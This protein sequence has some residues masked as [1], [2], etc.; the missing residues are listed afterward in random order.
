MWRDKEAQEAIAF[1]AEQA[2]EEMRDIP[3]SD[4][5]CDV[6][7]IYFWKE[8]EG[9]YKLLE[10]DPAEFANAI[11]EDRDLFTVIPPP[12]NGRAQCHVLRTYRKNYA[13]KHHVKFEEYACMYKGECKG[14]CQYCEQEAESL[15]RKAE[16]LPLRIEKLSLLTTQIAG[17]M[18]LRED[19]DG[20]GIRSLV[21]FDG[22][23]LH[24]EYCINRDTIRLLPTKMTLD[25]G[26]LGHLLMEDAVY[27]EM[28]GGG[29]TF[30]GGEPLQYYGF[31][32]QF[33][34]MY[35]MWDIAIETSLN[36]PLKNVKSLASK[37]N[38]W[39]IDIKDM[40]SDIYYCY[41]GL[42]NGQVI[43]NLQYLIDSGFRDR[44]TCRV[45]LIPGYNTKED[46]EQSVSY[47][48]WMG[49]I[50][51]DYFTYTVC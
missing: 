49:I 14:T 41:T 6:Y 39:Y 48:K 44:I 1:F 50:H 27:F 30:G 45:P 36:M 5:H 37:I 12:K 40:D 2:K 7:H 51:F 35:P 32:A 13:K 17:I 33:H 31:I 26:T 20:P 9:K 19:M 34:E 22:C 43:I 21:V 15:F 28:T 16:K 8:Q 29:V 47:L 3:F 11:L 46:V 24:C 25:A 23:P 10:R 38:H 4:L 42:D 18:R